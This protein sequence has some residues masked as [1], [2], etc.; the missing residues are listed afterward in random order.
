MVVPREDVDAD[1]V[2]AE[3]ACAA[4]AEAVRAAADD[5]DDDSLAAHP[6]L[7]AVG[8]TAAV[9]L[10][11]LR[12]ALDGALLE[13]QEALR[14][15]HPPQP[16]L[17]QRAAEWAAVRWRPS[18]RG[19]GGDVGGGGG[20]A[21]GGGEEDREELAEL[22]GRGRVVGRDFLE[23]DEEEAREERRRARA[24]GV[25]EAG[26]AARRRRPQRAGRPLQQRGEQL[27]ELHLEGRRRCRRLAAAAEE[28]LRRVE[29]EEVKVRVAVGLAA[30]TGTM[31]KPMFGVWG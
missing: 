30:R 7:W 28:R 27:R 11:E 19:G 15:A 26:E 23:V 3:R 8:G 4:I 12:A 22:L 5:G 16:S 31:R 1:S 20:G 29:E 14:D 13:A 6:L 18:W 21:G 17:A 25:E 2:A 10:R 9:D 24:A